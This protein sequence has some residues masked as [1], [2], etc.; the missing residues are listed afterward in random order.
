MLKLCEL[1]DL[2]KIKLGH[3]KIHCA[4]CPA[5]SL[6]APLTAYLDGKFQEWQEWQ[7]RRNFKCDRIIS[8]IHLTADKWLFV[9]VW[10]VLDVKANVPRL[11]SS[12]LWFK[13]STS[14]VPGLEHLAGKTIISFKRGFRN[15]YP[16]GKNNADKL[17]V[18]QILEERMT[19][20]DFP[21]YSSVLLT[22]DELRYIVTHN[23]TSWQSALKSVAGIYLVTDTS[24]GK[25]YVGS[26][27]G[28][29]GLW[30]RWQFYADPSSSHGNNVELKDLLKKS[31]HT[32]AKHFQFSILE[33]CDR[34]ATEVEVFARESHWKSALYSREF[35]YNSN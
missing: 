9:G 8:L 21:G 13:Y 24:C 31:G 15:P 28:I 11:N 26:A 3:F 23:L 7:S 10:N 4:T 27:Y 29:D 1:L 20:K 33:I 16:L 19:M 2:A 32:H 35:G 6:N 12:K 18:A 17:L 5:N 30:G 14:E 22:H 25:H 34:L